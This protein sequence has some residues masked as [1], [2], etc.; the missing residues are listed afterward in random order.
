M[1]AL[2]VP[3]ARPNAQQQLLYAYS[4]CLRVTATK[5]QTIALPYKL[6]QPA[7]PFAFQ[8]ADERPKDL[9]LP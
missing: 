1:A 9:Y 7:Q 2:F 8:A 3:A 4:V 6:D 5:A